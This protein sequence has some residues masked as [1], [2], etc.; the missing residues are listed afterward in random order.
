VDLVG[1][2]TTRSV[3]SVATTSS[4]HCVKEI[5]V[6]DKSISRRKGQLT[7]DEITTCMI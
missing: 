3:G 6:Q 2:R 1:D 5:S 4:E 7:F